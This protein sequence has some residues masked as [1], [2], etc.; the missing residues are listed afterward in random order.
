M[1]IRCCRRNRLKTTLFLL[2]YNIA[3]QFLTFDKGY[4]SGSVWLDCD[5]ENG[6]DKIRAIRTQSKPGVLILSYVICS[7]FNAASPRIHTREQRPGFLY[8][9]GTTNQHFTTTN[10]IVRDEATWQAATIATYRECRHP[11]S[12]HF[13]EA[14][15]KLPSMQRR[16][17]TSSQ[18]LQI[19]P[20]HMQALHYVFLSFSFCQLSFCSST[21]QKKSLDT[22]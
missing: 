2:V 12:R 3:S 4:L 17:Q 14:K 19:K 18:N 22:S 11:L 16:R 7:L 10:F 6:S 21:F 9:C 5:S 8:L 1:I 15:K 13:A 20:R